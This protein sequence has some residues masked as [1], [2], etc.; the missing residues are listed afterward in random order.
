MEDLQEQK[1]SAISDAR[2]ELCAA[3]EEA[4]T[5]RRAVQAAAAER[6]REI[7]AIQGNLGTVTAELEKWRQAAATYEMEIGSL[8]TSLQRQSRQCERAVQLQGNACPPPPH[9]AFAGRPT[10]QTSASVRKPIKLFYSTR[11]WMLLGSG[12]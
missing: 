9:G 3:Q 2:E 8:Q 5:L 6:D 12:M 7:A 4:L 11:R 10:H 1:E